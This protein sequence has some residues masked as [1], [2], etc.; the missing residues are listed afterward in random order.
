M[1][2][3]E[4]QT[5]LGNAADSAKLTSPPPITVNSKSA[6]NVSRC[7]APLLLVVTLIAVAFARIRLLGLPLERDEGEYAYAGQ[8]LLHGIAPYKL[9]YSMKFPGTAAAYALLM[10]IFGQSTMGIHIGLILINVT[11]I[12]FTFLLGRKLLGELGGIVAAAGY[13]V[14]SLMPHV[15]GQA[16]HATHFVVLFA[17]AG[18]LVLIRSLDRQSRL[19]IFTSGCFFGFALLMKQPGLFFVL[20]GSIYLAGRDWCAQLKAQ[21]IIRRNLLFI[22]G[23]SMPC[24]V[25]SL[26]LWKTGVFEKFWFWTVKYAGQYGSQVSITEGLR[27]LANH[28]WTVLGTAWPVWTIA[29]IGLVMCVANP[30]FR[31][32]AGFSLTFT[33][34]SAISVCPGFYFRPHYFILFLPAVSLLTAA[35]VVSATK[36]FPM[37][38]HNFRFAVLMLFALCLAWPLWS[39]ADFFFERPLPEANRMVNGTNP[40]PESIKIAEYIRTQSNPSDTIA[41]LGSEPQIYFYSNRRSAT[42]YIYTYALM[43]PQP[44]VHLIQQEMIGEIETARPKFLV[45]VVVNKSWLAGSDSDQTIFR[46]ADRYCEANYEEVGLINISDQGTDYYFS[47]TPP[48]VTPTAEHIL[49]FR[50]KT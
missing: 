41:V 46:W 19:L 22:I 36:A 4:I 2:P 39:E 16:A 7:A 27:I 26:A 45:L 37:P 25:T 44:Y 6:R 24:L 43:E 18:T 40:F 21:D 8:L 1:P 13:S 38:G 9:A 31:V 29:A 17:V 12:G 3:F 35:A 10:S 49:I 32:H 15:L 5:R 47:G 34:F 23:A 30:K 11:T 50:R 14:L 28:F 42:G 33:F 20:F 48:G